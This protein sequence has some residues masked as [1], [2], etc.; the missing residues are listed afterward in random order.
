MKRFKN[1][2][3]LPVAPAVWKDPVNGHKEEFRSATQPFS[4]FLSR[5]WAYCDQ[6]GRERPTQEA[7]EDEICAQYPSWACVGPGFHSPAPA[8]Q[9]APHGGGGC[10]ACGKRS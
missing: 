5:V 8:A 6:N 10:R 4:S 3:S 7:I 2:N 1:V 9:S